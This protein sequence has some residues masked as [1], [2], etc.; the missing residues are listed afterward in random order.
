MADTIVDANRTI[1]GF[2]LLDLDETAE[3]PSGSW[4]RFGTP[5]V[6]LSWI[7]GLLVVWLL[8]VGRG[9]LGDA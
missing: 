3:E 5:G 1:Q 4:P 9:V 2:S 8:G 7:F 6:A